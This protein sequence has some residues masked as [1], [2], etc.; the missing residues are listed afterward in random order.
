MR[1]SLSFPEAVFLDWDGTLVDSYKFLYNAHNYAQRSLGIRECTIDEFEKYFGRPREQLYKDLY[2]PHSRE[3]QA[4]FESYVTKNHL[5]DLKPMEGAK[6]LLEALLDLDIPAGLVSNKRSDFIRAEVQNFGWESFFVSV[7]GA[8]EAMQDKPSAA[9][10]L[11]AIER[12]SL[13]SN[14]NKIWYIGDTE[15]DLQ[16]AKN[17][18]CPSVFV[19]TPQEI[20]HNLQEYKP[21]LIVK[22]CTEL[23][24]FLLQ[25]HEN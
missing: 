25:C 22:N 20:D 4:L 14:L 8:G 9:P 19:Q 15:T 3:A 23:K 10:L 2:G 5:N 1:M 17:A 12:A 13:A 24:E 21:V 16:C 18:G 11:L 7:V 6:D